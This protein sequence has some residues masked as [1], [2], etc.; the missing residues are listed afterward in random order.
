MRVAL[1]EKRKESL[2]LMKLLKLFF[3]TVVVYKAYMFVLFFERIKREIFLK[4]FEIVLNLI[5][6]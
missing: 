5:I 6:F 4:K 2:N 1:G 3:S